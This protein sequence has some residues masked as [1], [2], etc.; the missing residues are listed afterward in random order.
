M[1]H[2]ALVLLVVFL[3]ASGFLYAQTETPFDCT[4]PVQQLETESGIL[5]VL[6]GD[7]TLE[8]LDETVF[9]LKM[10]E[11]QLL[12]EE[13]LPA[14][15]L[16]Q[17]ASPTTLTVND[18]EI[19]FEGRI[20]LQLDLKLNVLFLLVLDGSAEVDGTIVDE[21]FLMQALLAEDGRGLASPW[22]G[23][24]PFSAREE[25]VLASIEEIVAALPEGTAAATPVLPTVPPTCTV[26]TDWPTYRV[27]AGE[28]LSQIAARTGSSV[29]QL[30][31]A[32][33][34][35]DANLIRQ[36]QLLRV[37]RLPAVAAPTQTRSAPTQTPSATFTSTDAVIA[38]ATAPSTSTPT[39]TDISATEP[40]GDN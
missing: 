19:A 26:R 35:S 31:Q 33:C 29:Q 11:A 9:D 5:Y 13:Q 18:A 30:A 27:G 7:T 20:A 14:L 34:I 3:L 32:N 4:D 38:S 25:A 2:S 36:G 12:C 1:R 8:N 6:I 28:T 21:G 37:P 22:L 10:G 15:L 16:V 17:S 40:V 23:N 39:S 24:R